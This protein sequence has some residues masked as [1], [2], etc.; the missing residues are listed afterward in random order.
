[1]NVGGGYHLPTGDIVAYASEDLDNPAG[2]KVKNSSLIVHELTHGGTLNK[3]H[4]L[5]YNEALAGLGESSYLQW[6]EKRG[7]W[8]QAGS[9]VIN[10]AGV[11]LDLPGKFRYYEYASTEKSNTSQ[12]LIAASGME[13]G[14]QSSGLETSQLFDASTLNGD[15]QFA[16]MKDALDSIQPGLS[17]EVETFPQNTD[18]IIQASSVVHEATAKRIA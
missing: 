14:L 12:G 17:Q 15:K 5:F 6:L 13:L 10:R 2:A 7:R 8:Q 9:F 16:L 3:E 4:H 18:G 1:L 11:K